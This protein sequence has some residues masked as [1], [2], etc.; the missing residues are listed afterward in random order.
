[1]MK[2]SGRTVPALLTLV[3]AVAFSGLAQANLI[4][5]GGGF[6]D[7]ALSS[8]PSL[9]ANEFRPQPNYSYPGASGPAVI[10]GWSYA[11]GAGI[12]DTSQGWNAWY[13]AA[14]PSGYEGN[15]FA[16]LQ[17]GAA[18][19]LSTSFYSALAG[20]TQINWLEA[21]RP[22]WGCCNGDQTYLVELNGTLLGT[23]SVTSGQAF[24]SESVT[25]FL[26]AGNNILSF[27]SATPTSSISMDETVFLDAVSVA[28]IPEPSTWAMM[29]MGFV[30]LAFAAYR[31][32]CSNASRLRSA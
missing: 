28:A 27:I 31:R 11:A 15:Q 18:S 20:S 19:V 5:D 13:G 26:V 29:I 1:M 3:A 23:Y 16:F 32:R 2:F 17:G 6:E 21:G 22:F 8:H 30:G 9:G 7:P 24:T 25:G 14:A 4:T 12:V 10:N